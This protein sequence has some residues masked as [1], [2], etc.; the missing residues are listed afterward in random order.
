MQGPRASGVCALN[1]SAVLRHR[2]QCAVLVF[3]NSSGCGLIRS[4]WACMVA[5]VAR[6]AFSETVIG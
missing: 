6:I 4:A 2:M 3:S 5:S 1:L